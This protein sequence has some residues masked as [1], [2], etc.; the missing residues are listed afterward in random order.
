MQADFDLGIL[1]PLGVLAILGSVWLVLKRM[2]DRGTKRF[3]E[4]ETRQL[5]EADTNRLPGPLGDYAIWLTEDEPIEAYVVLDTATSGT[6]Q[7][8]DEYNRLRDRWQEAGCIV[9]R[10]A[11]FE[12]VYTSAINGRDYKLGIFEGFDEATQAVA[13]AHR[14]SVAR[15]QKAKSQ[16]DAAAKA[17]RS[18]KGLHEITS[19]LSPHRPEP[20]GARSV[21]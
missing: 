12:A 16:L 15:R 2:E 4:R 1:V 20:T 21:D 3:V 7:S 8:D 18:E 6:A 17:G 19:T 14:K 10:D 13:E 9:L 5:Q 11:G